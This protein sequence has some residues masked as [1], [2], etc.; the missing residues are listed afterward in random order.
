M[1]RFLAETLRDPQS[2]CGKGALLSPCRSYRYRLW[3]QWSDVGGRCAFVGLNPSTADETVD[4]ATIRKCVGFARRWGF[5]ALDM[6]NLF[7]WRSR[8]PDGLLDVADP[9]GPDNDRALLETFA[10]AGRIV[11][12]WGSHGPRVNALI[13]KRQGA[14]QRSAGIVGTCLVAESGNL[15]RCKNGAP[16]HP[17]MLAYVTEFQVTR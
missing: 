3:R 5:G 15:G 7:A 12:A 16:R 13:A 2:F 14:W 4:D 6:V 9:V 8:E 17:L 10:T 1:T 11:H